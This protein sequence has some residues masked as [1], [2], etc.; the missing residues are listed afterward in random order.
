LLQRTCTEQQQHNTFLINIC[1]SLSPGKFTLKWYNCFQQSE[2]HTHRCYQ[3]GFLIIPLLPC[4]LSWQTMDKFLHTAAPSWKFCG[5]CSSS[6]AYSM[7]LTKPVTE[8]YTVQKTTDNY[9]PGNRKKTPVPD[10][11]TPN[12]ILPEDHTAFNA[13]SS[14]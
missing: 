8:Y 3:E 11:Q 9:K 12:L 4:Y 1:R 7:P 5:R 14:K 6:Q 10:F 2:V 13:S